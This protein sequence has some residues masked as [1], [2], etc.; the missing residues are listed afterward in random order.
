MDNPTTQRTQTID[1]SPKVKAAQRL[2]ASL[3][4]DADLEMYLMDHPNAEK[5]ANRFWRDL[6]R[7]GDWTQDDDRQAA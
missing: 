4:D 3:Q 5:A 6:E 2:V 7:F 1:L